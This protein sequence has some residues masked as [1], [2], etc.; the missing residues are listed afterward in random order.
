MLKD[1]N[2]LRGSCLE[3]LESIGHD[4]PFSFNC[5]FEAAFACTKNVAWKESVSKWI[6]DIYSNVLKL[7]SELQDGS[8]KISDPYVFHI[9]DPKP[10]TVSATAFRDRVVQRS[11]CD[12]GL[13][14]ALTNG[15]IYDN[16]ACQKQKGVSFAIKRLTEHLHRYYRQHHTNIGYI[17]RLDVRKYFPSIPH[18]KLK[19]SLKS[20]NL[21]PKIYDMLCMIIDESV[22]IK[23]EDDISFNN[24][25]FGIRGIGLGSQISQLLA[26]HYL[27]KLDHKLK[28]R[29]HVKHY[30]RYMDDMIMIVD[31]KAEAER[32]FRFVSDFLEPLGLKLNPKSKIVR[33]DQ[34][35]EFLKMIYR[36]TPTGK[37]K[38]RVV[39]RG[40][41]K[42]IKTAHS[43]CR[44][45]LANKNITIEKLLEHTNTWFGYA[46]HRAS[47]NQ[48][49]YIKHLYAELLKDFKKIQI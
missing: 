16:C 44:Q 6:M 37:V 35:F 32:L 34:P 25:G 22:K 41:N 5:L 1:D 14:K 18:Q 39:R 15:L 3:T 23:S 38:R 27:S 43:L 17:V 24:P 33:L 26:L 42:E 8:Y 13:Y 19:E 12:N 49:R 29:Q 30:L 2:T 9:T 28:E 40:I 46:K 48:I 7:H 45:F 11:M 36:L 21:E 31:S 20:V 4:D 47:R 10:R